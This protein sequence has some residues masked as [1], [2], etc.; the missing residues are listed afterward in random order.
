MRVCVCV[1]VCACQSGMKCVG[2]MDER[3]AKW[4][5]K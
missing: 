2:W 1:H 5:S 4:R 3:E